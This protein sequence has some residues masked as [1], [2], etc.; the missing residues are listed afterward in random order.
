MGDRGTYKTKITE[1]GKQRYLMAS[2]KNV[3]FLCDRLLLYPPGAGMFMC[4]AN[5]LMDVRGRYLIASYDGD[6]VQ[7]NG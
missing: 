2:T 3:V 6:V 4:L 5:C 1:E 7:E